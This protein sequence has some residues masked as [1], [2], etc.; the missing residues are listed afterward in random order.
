M[1]Q[2]VGKAGIQIELRPGTIIVLHEK[3]P[4]VVDIASRIYRCCICE[5]LVVTLRVEAYQ[6][7]PVG[8]IRWI[9]S[10]IVGGAIE[11][12]IKLTS[13]S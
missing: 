2:I 8:R 7:V 11:I 1:S 9:S 3:L 12:V 6:V 4:V 10:A 13:R 5:E